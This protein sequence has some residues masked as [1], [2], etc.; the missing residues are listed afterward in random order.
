MWLTYQARTVVL[1]TVCKT[2]GCLGCRDRLLSLFKARVVTGASILGRCAFITLT[3]RVQSIERRTA[4]DVARN[5]A[6]LLLRM[7]RTGWNVEWLKVPELT[8]AGQPHLHV[9]MGPM[10]GKIRC[11]GSEGLRTARFLRTAGSCSCVSHALSAMWREVTGDSWVVHAVPVLGRRGAGSY[12][13]KYMAKDHVQREALIEAGFNRRWSTSRGW[14]GGGR[15]R[16]AQSN[17]AGGPGWDRVD[18]IPGKIGRYVPADETGLDRKVG[19]PALAAYFERL[20]REAAVSYIM[21]R[22]RHDG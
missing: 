12:L 22:T 6:A 21:R 19:P 13:A 10:L 5:W 17:S 4:Q 3:Y 7:K 20:G 2:W 16:L 18:M 14:P 11:Y 1:P 15:I 9:L 8:K